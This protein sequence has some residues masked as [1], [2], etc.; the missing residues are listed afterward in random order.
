MK[1]KEPEI[2]LNDLN[3]MDQ[4]LLKEKKLEE[5]L[6]ISYSSS[7]NNEE[8]F[9]NPNNLNKVQNPQLQQNIIQNPL[10]CDSF[11]TKN[12]DSVRHSSSLSKD[13][14][15]SSSSNYK[16][17]MV[18]N[19][20][21]RSKSRKISYSKSSSVSSSRSKNKFYSKLPNEMRRSSY[22]GHTN[23]NNAYY[24]HNDFR[25]FDKYNRNKTNNYDHN[26]NML[27]MMMII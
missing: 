20:R 14:C 4:D 5:K 11:K 23:R 13:V 19:K 7:D 27:M 1:K 9:K 2:N 8:Y 6:N 10:S 15:R 25:K 22:Y 12:S 21:K 16:K 24:E 3:L 26:E 17:N 18:G